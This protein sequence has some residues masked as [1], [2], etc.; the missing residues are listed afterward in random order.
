MVKHIQGCSNVKTSI[1][2]ERILH[3]VFIPSIDEERILRFVSVLP[4]I[5]E[6]QILRFIFIPSIVEEQIL[7]FIFV[8]SIVEE[9]ILCFVFIPSIVEDQ[10]LRFVFVPSIVEEQILC[11]VFVPSI[12][13][14]QILRFILVPSTVKDQILWFVFVPSIVEEQILCFVFVPS[15]VEEQILWFVFIPSIVEEQRL[16]FTF[17]PSI[18]GAHTYISFL[19]A[20]L[21]LFILIIIFFAVTVNLILQWPY[22]ILALHLLACEEQILWFVFVPFIVIVKFFSEFIRGLVFKHKRAALPSTTD[23][24]TNRVLPKYS[25][26]EDL[27][28]ANHSLLRTFADDPRPRVKS[29]WSF[30]GQVRFKPHHEDKIYKVTSLLDIYDKLVFASANTQRRAP[31]GNT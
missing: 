3:L 23:L 10:I 7:R 6:E 17:V 30:G 9:Q 27:T 22:E 5:V 4:S 26:F 24:S 15:I 14:E 13:E 29:A 8:P 2:E 31:L 11:F 20:W 19:P 12:V 25:I 16:C 1:V 18:V 21:K 28:A